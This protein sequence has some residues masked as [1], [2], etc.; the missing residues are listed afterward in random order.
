MPVIAISAVLDP[1]AGAYKVNK[2]YLRA[3][4]AAG[5]TPL[6]VPA[7]PQA[8]LPREAQGLLLPGGDDVCPV[9]YGEEAHPALGP[10]LLEND[11]GEFDLLADA[12]RRG[13]PV[14]AICRGMQV[15][16]VCFGGTLWQDLPAQRPGAI[17]HNQAPAPRGATAHTAALA[18]ESRLARLMGC[19]RLAVNTFHHQAVKEPAPGFAV[20]A[21]ADDGMIEAIESEQILAVQWHPE[22]L[23]EAPHARLFEDLIRRAKNA[24]IAKNT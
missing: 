15:V 3:V 13:L 6:L 21:R 10:T 11:L 16:N 14:L 7:L 8:P 4:C 24:A 23:S 20:S 1:A 12:L 19:G 9:C 17:R 2:A 5:G 22:L 18:P